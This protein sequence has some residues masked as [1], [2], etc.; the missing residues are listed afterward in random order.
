MPSIQ[1]ELCFAGTAIPKSIAIETEGAI[2]HQPVYG[3]SKVF[4]EE[5]VI[6]W[7]TSTIVRKIFDGNSS[8]I[9]L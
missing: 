4:V 9:E 3:D 1:E 6:L 8:A 5:G 2:L 7:Q